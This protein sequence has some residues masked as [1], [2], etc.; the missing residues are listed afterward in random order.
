MSLV[1]A[2][3]RRLLAR[4]AVA[5]LLVAG[6]VLAAL[7][8]AA[9]AWEGRPVSGSERALGE[10]QYQQELAACEEN[11]R[12]YGGGRG[13]ECADAVMPPEAYSYRQVLSTEAVLDGLLPSLTTLL[14]LVALIVGTTF[15]GAEWVS[16]SMSN[17]LLFE[18]RRGRVWLAKVVVVAVVGTAFA[19]LVLGL[20]I[21]GSLAAAISWSDASW[22]STRSWYAAYSILRGIIVVVTIAVVGVAITLALRSTIATVGLAFGYAM[23]GEAMLRAINREAVEPWLLSSHMVAFLNGELKLYGDSFARRPEVTVLHLQTSALYLGALML[24]L[25]VVS[26]LTFRRRDIA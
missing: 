16:G 9:V 17:L 3:L 12:R 25:L 23:V 19:T 24:V 18:P 7:V 15:V 20:A 4:R 6:L 13:F 8:T 21:A 2:E 1:L 11:P 26:W 10:E 14:G 22:G 5:L